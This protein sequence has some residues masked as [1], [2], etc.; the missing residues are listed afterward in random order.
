ME[1]KNKGIKVDRIKMET[2]L[3]IFLAII[4][5]TFALSYL[6]FTLEDITPAKEK[7]QH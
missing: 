6:Y 4:V 3:K 1:R 2:V 7:E 5:L